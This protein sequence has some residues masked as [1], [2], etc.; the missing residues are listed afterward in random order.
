MVILAMI[1]ISLVWGMQGT[2]YTRQARGRRGIAREGLLA[3]WMLRYIRR[4]VHRTGRW[5]VKIAGPQAVLV[6]QQDNHLQPTGERRLAQHHHDFHCE[7]H[8]L[9]D[10]GETHDDNNNGTPGLVPIP[11]ALSHIM[12]ADDTILHNPYAG[13]MHLVFDSRS[14]FHAVR[15]CPGIIATLEE[16]KETDGDS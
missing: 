4:M 9:N 2:A 15:T 16:N 5:L 11:K 8:Q 12:F 14:P 10:L 13:P 7:T 6:C 3:H 1:A